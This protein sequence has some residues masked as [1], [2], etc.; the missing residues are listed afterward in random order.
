[1]VLVFNPDTHE[2]SWA[3]GFFD[4]EGTTHLRKLSN[5]SRFAMIGIS[6]VNRKNLERFKT[7]VGG[8]GCIYGPYNKKEKNRLPIYMYHATSFAHTQA[9]VAMLWSRLGDEKRKQAML[10]LIAC[11]NNPG[12]KPGE[13]NL[14][15]NSELMKKR[16]TE[17]REKML[18][19]ARTNQEKAANSLRGKP[20]TEQQL[21]NL[22]KGRLRRLNG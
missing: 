19:I 9:V 2:L 6:Q 11:K 14:R 8:I 5:N 17:S 3:A 20:P 16:W 10:A 1:M 15:V 12:R 21:L 4:G 22:A 13:L 18:I 7:A